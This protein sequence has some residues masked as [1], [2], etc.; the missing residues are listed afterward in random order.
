MILRCGK[1]YWFQNDWKNIE[2][3]FLVRLFRRLGIDYIPFSVRRCKE[4]YLR[5]E[6]SRYN[7]KLVNYCKKHGITT[8]IVEEGARYAQV[9]TGHIPFRADY[10]VCMEENYLFWLKFI[11]N[12]QIITHRPEKRTE[13]YKE[14]VFMYPF[15]TRENRLHPMRH[16]GM[17]ITV[18]KVIEHFLKKDVVFKLHPKNKHIVEQFIPK[19]RL[20]TG[21]AEDLIKKYE[22]VYCFKTCSIRKDCEM[23]DVTPIFVEDCLMCIE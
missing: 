19:H 7:R 20:V 12:G 1:L 22:K 13:D 10:F 4:I 9:Q 16:N 6:K 3:F 23:L 2:D 21:Q 11:P 5:E 18:M 17:N 14:I 8:Y 15:Y